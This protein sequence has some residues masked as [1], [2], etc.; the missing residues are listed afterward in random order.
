VQIKEGLIAI[1][2]IADRLQLRLESL[3]LGDRQSGSLGDRLQ[4]EIIF[5]APDGNL[6]RYLFSDFPK[7]S[8][9]FYFDIAH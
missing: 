1:Q 8:G 2:E 3:E 5:E 6:R 7:G 4:R 9:L